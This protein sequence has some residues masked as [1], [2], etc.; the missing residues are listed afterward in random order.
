MFIPAA[1]T[2][3]NTPA[4]MDVD[5]ESRLAAGKSSEDKKED[6]YDDVMNDPAFLQSVL[7]GLPGV[8]PES[9]AIKNAMDTITQKD[10]GKKDDKEKEGQ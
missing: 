7:E 8:D 3:E 6:N 10:S 4:P 2:T 5:E 9:D 1:N